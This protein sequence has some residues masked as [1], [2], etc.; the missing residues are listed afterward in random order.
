MS[1]KAKRRGAGSMLRPLAVAAALAL[2]LVA[3]GDPPPGQTFYQ[4]KIEPIL[5]QSCAGNTS[6]CHETR[7]GDPFKFAAGNFDVTSFASVQKRRD[8]LRPFGAYQIPLLLI[9]SVGTGELRVA[10]GDVA[11]PLEVVHAGGPIFQ[12]G[13]DAYQTLL[14]WTEN[15]ATEN[16]RPPLTP[17]QPGSGNCSEEVPGTFV[18]A[19]FLANPNFAEFRDR[20][21][22]ILDGCSASSCHGAA[23]SDFYITCGHDPRQQAFN[24]S[25]SWAFIDAPVD[26]SQLLRVPLA[27][28]EGGG[29]HTGGDQLASRTAEDYLAIRDW[30]TKVG[31]IDFGAGD[32]GKQFFA[33]HVQPRL[34]TRGCAFEGCH[35]P[36]AA[37]DFKLRS[38]SLG[39]FSAVV[40][41]K[42]YEL[43]KHEFMALEVPDAR[44]G[45]AVAKAILPEDGGIAHRAGAVFGEGDPADCG[46][47]VAAT[48]SP[49]CTLQEWVRIER[50][51]MV[52]RGEIDLMDAG[53][54]V[55]LVYVER[56]TSHVAGPLQFDTYQGGSDL[57]VAPATLGARGA[58]ASVGG[59]TSLLGAC[60]V[61]L[62][63][64]D[65]RA[66]DVRHDGTTIAFAMRTGP[67]DPLGIWTVDVSGANCRRVTAAAPD[68][69]GLKLHNFDP[70][71]SPDGEWIVFASTRGTAGPG[72]SRKLFLPQSDLW[73]M[74][75]D[76][77]GVEQVTYLT[78]SELGPQ[79]MREGRI[80]MTT[81]KVS[82]GFYQL[83]GRRINWDRTDYHPLLAQRATSP[84]ADLADPAATR[85]SVGYGQATD[86]REDL[87]GNFLTIFS[88]PGA[89]GG[90]GTL[91]IFNRSIGPFEA[92]RTELGFLP[93]VR[94][95]DPAATGRV[96]A[97]TSGAYRNPVG[98]PDGRIM[99]SYAAFTGDLGA[100][101]S[102]D[103]NLVAI[104]P[105]TGAR[106]A[107]VPAGAGA[108]VDAVLGVKRPAGK[109]YYNRR[110]LVFGGHGGADQDRAIVHIPDAPLTFTL[111]TGNLRR[112]R[113]VDDFR[114]REQLAV[115]A[116]NPA[117]PGTTTGSGPG[118]IFE[119]R[120]D[121]GTAS[122]ASDGSVRVN[123]PAA[124]AL[125]LELRG[126]AGPI[127]MGEEH[128]LGPGEV[129][130]LGIRASLF[131]SVCGGCHGS[132]SGSELD[133][134]ITPDALTGASESLSK[135]SEARIE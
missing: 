109:L 105:A 127:N 4:R 135:N 113:P 94:I 47:F 66:P 10:Y 32:P 22:P 110:Q 95:V 35:S 3:C 83:A 48:A 28:G 54:T 1:M 64:A 129:V 36:S 38:G 68:V 89:R 120:T 80:T 121:L 119:S 84:Y 16:N 8:L 96:G 73:R 93:S 12:V 97:P 37:N 31:R 133:I 132:I 77:T 88:D 15:G 114:S 123:V 108:Q 61:N 30:A 60:G 41:E 102:L 72:L 106:T 40:L 59:S 55:P 104:D 13:S 126:G 69:S 71:W 27:R 70:A 11:R 62:A 53:D 115:Y 52:A 124:R 29:P 101:T 125:V 5:L 92:G 18:E 2:T 25:Q 98:L 58:I 122:L 56:A 82:G 34:L 65:V 23:Q 90:A 103:W 57:R 20:I 100:A 17:A 26:E 99:V 75:R 45:R 33:T 9:K 21:Q 112:G 51:A 134:A 128:Q 131:D 117:P 44:R 130:T 87:N 107:L 6:G 42:N 76:G 7:P 14:D 91:A 86:I 63:S 19:S 24:F 79:M 81:E 50:A 111:L 118:G 43:L 85:P 46:G 67:T 74:R 49:F 116:E 39:F 78:N